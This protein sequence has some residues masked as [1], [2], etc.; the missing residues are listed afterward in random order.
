ME[1]LETKII[2]KLEKAILLNCENVP[3]T[4]DDQDFRSKIIK[5]CFHGSDVIIDYEKKK[6]FMNL[7]LKNNTSAYGEK[8]FGPSLIPFIVTY[9][10]LGVFLKTCI[11]KDNLSIT[12]YARTMAT[13]ERPEIIQPKNF[14]GIEEHSF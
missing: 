7:I 1:T 4:F 9:D 12:F 11:V 6:I 14:V 3:G 13:Y 10:N 2:S 8:F 5:W